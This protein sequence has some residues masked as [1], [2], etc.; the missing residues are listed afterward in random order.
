MEEIKYLVNGVEKNIT[1]FDSYK[2]LL[3]QHQVNHTVIKMYNQVFLNFDE[4]TFLHS[5]HDGHSNI[6]KRLYLVN[7]ISFDENTFLD[8][9]NHFIKHNYNYTYTYKRTYIDYENVL[10]G[11]R[12]NRIP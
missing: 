11:Q 5:I 3:K 2:T 12:L 4:Y 7:D 6:S 1:I 9:V 8:R 10:I